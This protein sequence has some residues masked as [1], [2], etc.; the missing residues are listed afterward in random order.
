SR[1]PA[2]CFGSWPP[3]PG[4][5]ALSHR[6]PRVQAS[7]RYERAIAALADLL[8]KLR[9]EAVF[10]GSVARSVWLGS[11]VDKGSLEVVALMNP[12]QKGQVAMMAS[13]RGFR[14]DSDEVEH[15]AELD[16]N[17]LYFRDDDG[18]VGVDVIAASNALYGRIVRDAVAK[19]N[20]R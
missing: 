9:L 1:S 5:D 10:V 20:I 7:P 8:S 17:V 14:V 6:I 11:R 12:E 19:E 3:L 18:A 13:N 16:L 15:T 2:G 4:A